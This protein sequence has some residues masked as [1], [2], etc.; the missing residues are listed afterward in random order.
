MMLEATN[1]LRSI[2]IAPSKLHIQYFGRWDKT[3]ANNYRCAQGAVYIKLS[4][5][6]TSIK[7]RMLDKENYWTCYRTR[8]NL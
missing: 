5:T 8:D 6:G 4:F 2:H 3:D 7:V 1:Q